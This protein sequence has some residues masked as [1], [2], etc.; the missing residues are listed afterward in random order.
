MLLQI[1]LC[2]IPALPDAL[3][4][5]REPAAGLVDELQ[6]H[7]KVYEFSP[8]GN[9]LAVHDIEDGLFKRR[10]DLVFDDLGARAV[11]DD[12]CAVLDGLGPADVDTNGRVELECVATRGRLGVSVHDADLHTKLVDEDDD[13]VRFCD[14]AGELSK[15]L[16]HQ[17]CL[18]AD[19]GIAHL[20]FNF[21]ARRQR[22][23][24]VDHYH[25]HRT[26]ADERIC[27]LQRLLAGIWLGDE[28]GVDV[29]TDSRRIV[30]VQRVLR[31]HECDLT[32]ALLRLRHNV[33][34]QRRLTGGFRPVN[35]NDSAL[36]HAADAERRV[37][38]Q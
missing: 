20:A 26:R 1:E 23:D 15:R 28:H 17:P 11:A 3:V 27:N 13:T 38:S 12:L 4:P 14:V 36:R 25:V 19:E 2:V 31:V 24:R 5:N 34:R 29:H 33:K 32:A 37:Q 35:L 16:R 10:R 9:A 22:R 30:R 18:K 21:C 8:L 6:L 7:G